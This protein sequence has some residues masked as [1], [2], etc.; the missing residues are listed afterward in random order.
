MLTEEIRNRRLLGI[1]Q[2]PRVDIGNGPSTPVAFR[3]RLSARTN[4]L[5][6]KT[7]ADNSLGHEQQGQFETFEGVEPNSVNPLD[8]TVYTE[9]RHFQQIFPGTVL[10]RFHPG[11]FQSPANG[12]AKR[13]VRA[14]VRASATLW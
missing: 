12:G 10:H 9:I 2:C 13:R 8:V 4:P 11:V 6:S 14:A 5:A 1:C 3:C 7:S